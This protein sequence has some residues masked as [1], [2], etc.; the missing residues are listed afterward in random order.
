MICG[1]TV[2]VFRGRS[3]IGPR[4]LGNRSLLALPHPVGMRDHIN[5]N[6]KSRE[7]FRPLAP[8]VPIEHLPT[9]FEGV[10]ESPFMLLVATVRADVRD[11]L[12]AVTHVDGTARVQTVRREDNPFLHRLLNLVGDSTGVPVLL[13]TSLNLR[14]EPIVEMPDDAVAMFLRCP[15]DMLVLEDRV[16]R[17]HSP[18]ATPS[19]ISSDA[20]LARTSR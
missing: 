15:I 11:Q 1:E 14:G 6:V 4:A 18:W 5:L 8:V 17:K 20:R 19:F 13:N 9:Y 12:P 10:E 2:A 3:E 16:A 7:S